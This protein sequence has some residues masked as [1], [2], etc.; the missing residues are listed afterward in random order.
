MQMFVDADEAYLTW[1]SRHPEGYVLNAGRRPAPSTP[2]V[3]HVAVCE[4]I[5]QRGVRY[6]TGD[7]VKVCS[8]DRQGLIEWAKRDD[9]DGEL[10]AD[11]SCLN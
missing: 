3:L 1:M 11:C 9:V 4:F 5:S 6:T 8:L 10:S 2:I 7:Y